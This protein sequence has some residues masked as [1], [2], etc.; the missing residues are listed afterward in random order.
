MK[1]FKL[2]NIR[3]FFNLSLLGILMVSFTACQKADVTEMTQ[4]SELP[5]FSIIKNHDYSRAAPKPV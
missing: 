3:Q 5:V 4:D 1:Q 2:A